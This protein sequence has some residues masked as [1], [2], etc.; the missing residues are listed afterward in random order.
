MIINVG[1]P[2][3]LSAEEFKGLANDMERW[4]G[5][6]YEMAYDDS[7][8]GLCDAWMLGTIPKMYEFYIY[9]NKILRDGDYTSGQLKELL[10]LQRYINFRLFIMNVLTL[11]GL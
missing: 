9:T 5:E 11:L 10:N 1:E 7:D 4:A 8:L 6:L 3:T 2:D